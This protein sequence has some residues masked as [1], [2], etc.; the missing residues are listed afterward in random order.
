M[1]KI[2]SNQIKSN[3]AEIEISV[4]LKVHAFF[5]FFLQFKKGKS[6]E[7]R[8]Q[9]TSIA[10]IKKRKNIAVSTTQHTTELLS[11]HMDRI[12]SGKRQRTRKHSHLPFICLNAKI[13]SRK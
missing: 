11:I 5:F 1:L 8:L 12:Q 13:D 10:A 3:V 9:E 6:K 2:K 4:S 7:K